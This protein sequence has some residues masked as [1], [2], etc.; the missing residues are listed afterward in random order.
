MKY[1]C[2]NRHCFAGMPGVVPPH[3]NYKGRQFKLIVQ[4][5]CWSGR[6]AISPRIG[7]LC[8]AIGL[9]LPMLI[10]SLL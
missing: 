4:A 5:Q 9:W 8:N 3:L 7:Y 2:H 10:Q 6:V 1:F